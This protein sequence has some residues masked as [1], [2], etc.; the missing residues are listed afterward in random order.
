MSEFY[1]NYKFTKNYH[2]R[3]LSR[4]ALIQDGTTYGR[5]N[6]LL[7]QI[8]FYENVILIDSLIINEKALAVTNAKTFVSRKQTYRIYSL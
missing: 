1:P 7:Y 8:E 5:W 6:E 2:N 4:R 3:H